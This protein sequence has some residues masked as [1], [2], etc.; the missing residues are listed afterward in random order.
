[1]KQINLS[2]LFLIL[3]LALGIF[4]GSRYIKINR[5]T[6]QPKISS[7]EPGTLPP[8]GNPN[9][10]VKVIEFGDF[11]CPFCFKAYKFIYPQ[12]EKYINEGK[13]VFYFRDFPLQSIHPQ[14]FNVHLASRCANEQGK[15]WEFHKQVFSDY[16]TLG[17]NTGNEDYLFSLSEKLKLNSEQFKECYNSKKYLNDIQND[18]QYGTNVGVE[19]TPTFFV[20]GKIVVGFDPNGL[21]KAIQEA[22]K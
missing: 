3:F 10:P 18:I 14:S 1:M 9:A 8:L 20:N 4:L 15:Y 2:V 11:H 12:L 21:E 17:Q 5:Q 13:I 7:I 6:P 16:E 22:L 19:G